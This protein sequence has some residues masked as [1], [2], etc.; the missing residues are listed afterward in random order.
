MKFNVFANVPDQDHIRSWVKLGSCETLEEFQ[1]I[2]EEYI[3]GGRLYLYGHYRFCDSCIQISNKKGIKEFVLLENSKV[4]FDR[5]NTNT[6]L[7][8]DKQFMI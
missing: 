8:T 7:G 6:V 1:K 3:K 4:L 5:H 2:K